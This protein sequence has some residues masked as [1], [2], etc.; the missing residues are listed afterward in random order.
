MYS[1]LNTSPVKLCYMEKWETDL[2]E[3][4]ELIEWHNMAQVASRS[5]INTSIIEANYKITNIF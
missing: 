5:L 2:Q 1:I 3:N 4:I